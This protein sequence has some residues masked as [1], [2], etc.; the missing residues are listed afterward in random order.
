MVEFTCIVYYMF[1]MQNIF[2]MLSVHVHLWQF[3]YPCTYIHV[4]YC[5][6]VG[7]YTPTSGTAVINDYDIRTN[8]DQIRQS[9]GIC[10]QHNVLF[11]RLT[12]LEHLKL[13]GRLKVCIHVC[14]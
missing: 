6:L 4:P 5:Y 13:F 14:V 11:D 10:P 1:M 12:V 8:M 7:L 3:C 2:S 9:L